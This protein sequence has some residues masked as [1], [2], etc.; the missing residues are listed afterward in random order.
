MQ[1]SDNAP[2]NGNVLSTGGWVI[3]ALAGTVFYWVLHYK[4]GYYLI[5]SVAF[6]VAIGLFVLLLLLIAVSRSA[7]IAAPSRVRKIV[8]VPERAVQDQPVKAAAPAAAASVVTPRFEAPKPVIDAPAPV[9]PLVKTAP[10]AEVAAPV[11]APEVAPIAKPKAKA[12]AKPKA[13]AQST[14]PARLKAARRG[15]A[16]DL[17][18]I[19]G[20]G[21]ALE[22]LVNSLGI[23]HFDQIAGW[24]DADVATVDAEMKGFKGRIA[25]DK[26]VA[27]ARIIAT[28][29]LEAFRERTKS[30][31]Y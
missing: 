8:P 5:S 12:A 4:L 23:Y 11:I 28:E 14:G 6:A 20:I 25:R 9:A 7:P 1:K 19:E 13:E 21:P 30:N 29:G 10:A 26:W 3:A 24:T 15:G 31:E 22:K 27:Q 16:D 17:K 18:E 2:D